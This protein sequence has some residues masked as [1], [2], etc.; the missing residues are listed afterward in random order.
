MINFSKFFI[1]FSHSDFT[2]KHKSQVTGIGLYTSYELIHLQMD[3]HI[4]VENELL[5]YGTKEYLGANFKIII[6]K[7]VPNEN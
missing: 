3:G 6:P 7:K 2:T 5:S 4:K 1:N